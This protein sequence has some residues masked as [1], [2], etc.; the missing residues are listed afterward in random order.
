MESEQ[1]QLDLSLLPEPA[2]IELLDFY[3]FLTQKYKLES[4]KVKN[5]KSPVRG[6]LKAYRNPQQIPLEK[7]LG[8]E[9]AMKEKYA[10]S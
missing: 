6:R 9:R 1:V 4:E 8:W 7:E 5:T 2:Q 10:K 3:K